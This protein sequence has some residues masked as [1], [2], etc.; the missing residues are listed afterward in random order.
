[1]AI[2]ESVAN[3]LHGLTEA[4]NESMK[5]IVVSGALANKYRSG[6][7]AWVRL[8]WILGFKRLGFRVY[9]VEEIKRATIVDAAGVPCAFGASVNLA[10]FNQI[11]RQFGIDESSALIYEGGQE[12]HGLSRGE[13]LELADTA[14]L[15]VNISG[16][17]DCQPYFSRFRRKA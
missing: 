8:N 12:I 16:H 7:E 5:T 15:L 3:S 6:G 14:D 10:Y 2:N 9:F 4:G 1:N 11:T 13:L 17:L